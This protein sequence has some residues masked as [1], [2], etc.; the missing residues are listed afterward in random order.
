MFK[1][2]EK[3]L[4]KLYL[5]NILIVLVVFI[6]LSFFLNIFEEIKYFDDKK[7]EL[8][9]PII[10]TILN[11]PS[12]IFEILP[13]IYLLGVMFFFIN[14]YENEEIE[15]LR[16]N[17]INN[18][19]I[20]LIVSIVS[21]TTGIIIILAYYSFSA[22]LKS[23]YLNMKYKY[24]DAGD[25]LAVVNQD[26]L[27]IKEK[28]IDG[29]KIY[30]INAKKYKIN[31]LENLEIIELDEDYKLINTI[32]SKT[33]NIDKKNW[34]LNNVKIYSDKKMVK[35]F[36]TYQYKSSFNSEIISNLYS[37]L[38]SLNIFQ[39]I[40]LQENYKSIGYSATEVKL[41]LNKIY[42]TPF[43]LTLTAI[44]GAL[45]MFKL[46]FIKSKFFMVVIGVTVSVIFYYINYFSILFGKNETLPVEISVWLPQ[47]LIFLICSLG[48]TKLN[49]N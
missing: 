44:I 29:S 9:Y 32:I 12:V 19:K 23:L 48:L 47:I 42:S 26:G 11:I 15:L 34:I 28:S 16:S 5:K 1:Q 24:S 14:L 46:S 3:Y 2:Y 43:Y 41:H 17:G 35:Y 40:E 38:N 33:A 37:N 36:E 21:I 22:N 18:M 31:K 39:L 49:E 10:L 27:W 4:T 6:F 45:L 13:F 20:T 30:I 8:Y 7:V 25:H